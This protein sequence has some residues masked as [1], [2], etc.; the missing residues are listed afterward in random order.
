MTQT[1]KIRDAE[2]IVDRGI[3]LCREG[4]KRSAAWVATVTDKL[5]NGERARHEMLLEKNSELAGD[6]AGIHCGDIAAVE[7]RTARLRRELARQR[8]QKRTFA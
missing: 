2:R 8:L 6:V 7:D 3:V 1:G 4:F 5:L